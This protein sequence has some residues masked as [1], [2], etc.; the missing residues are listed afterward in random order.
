MSFPKVVVESAILI[1]QLFIGRRHDKK[2]SFPYTTKNIFFNK[3]IK[4]NTNIYRVEDKTTTNIL[5]RNG[6]ADW[7]SL[8]PLLDF[9]STQRPPWPNSSWKFR[10]LVDKISVAVSLD[11]RSSGVVS[12]DTSLIVLSVSIF[13]V[14]PSLTVLEL[15]QDVW[16]LQRVRIRVKKK[17]LL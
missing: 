4:T 17:E 13:E 10:L 8:I 11:A 2:Q 5:P 15:L 9:R 1:G 14:S 6:M 7:G 12:P 16:F 3:K